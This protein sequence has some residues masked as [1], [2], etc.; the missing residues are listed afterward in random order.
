MN[1]PRM[2]QATRPTST[3]QTIFRLFLGANLL[4]TGIGHLS[5]ARTD[6]LAQVPNWLPL[7]GDLVVVASGIVE[8]LL[9]AALIGLGRYRVMTGWIVA[10]FFLIIFPGNISQYLNGID[11]FGMNSD[12]AR[13]LRLLFQPVLVAWAL[14]STGAWQAWRDSRQITPLKSEQHR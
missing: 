13:A 5:W 8:L 12:E 1:T 14:W 2:L 6:F 10:A 3:I 11:A 4:F 9:G 7:N